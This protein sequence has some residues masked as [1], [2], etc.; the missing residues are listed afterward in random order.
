M[1]VP[2]M[3]GETARPDLWM[4]HEVGRSLRVGHR[5]VEL[6]RYV[7]EPWDAQVES[8]RPYFHPMRTT[9]GAEVTLFRPHDHVWHKG[10]AWSLPNVGTENFWGGPTYVRGQD[11]QHLPNNGRTQHVDFPRIAASDDRLDVDEELEWITQRGDRWFTEQRRFGVHLLSSDAWALTY[12]T[13]FTNV[14]GQ[15]VPLGS[16]TTEGRP[17]AGYGGLFWRGPRSFSGGTV[18]TPTTSGKDELNGVRA[19]W[20]AFTGR[21]DGIDRSSTVVF[22]ESE[23]NDHGGNEH[24]EWFVR[25]DVYAV[26]S[27]SPFYSEVHDLDDGRSLTFRYAVVVADGSHDR[28]A[29]ATLAESAHHL[30]AGESDPS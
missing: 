11:Y 14:S 25:S 27:P 8:P 20:L 21:H 22:V 26:V 18:H 1:T 6:L 23:A 4:D 17:N 15:S 16:P 19:P 5:G 29:S 13:T 9:A 7:Y 24:T 2:A 28:A 10:I 12:T 3:T 30:L